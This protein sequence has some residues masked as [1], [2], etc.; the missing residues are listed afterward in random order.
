MSR[1]NTTFYYNYWLYISF[2]RFAVIQRIL[3]RQGIAATHNGATFDLAFQA[4]TVDDAADV[5]GGDHFADGT[6]V[7]EDADVGGIAV[8]DV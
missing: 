4:L 1:N 2:H 7:I 3:F 8:G 5:V 6:V